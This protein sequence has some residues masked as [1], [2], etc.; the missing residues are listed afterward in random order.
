MDLS[1]DYAA[2]DY[3]KKIFAEVP[4]QA[5]VVADGDEHLF[6]LQ[7]YGNVVAPQSDVVI[8]SVE[9]LQFSWYFEQVR[10]M[11]PGLSADGV[12]S[13]DRLVRVVDAGLEQGRGVY[14]TVRD[15]SFSR[16]AMEAH[17]SYFRVIGR[18]PR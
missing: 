17:D 2:Y 7:Y 1:S 10:K 12:A 14:S 16:Y 18:S 9:L 15:E 11:I 4:H 3:A 8:V 5:I 6:A 13:E